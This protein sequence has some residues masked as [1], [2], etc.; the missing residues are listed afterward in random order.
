MGRNGQ[1]RLRQPPLV[2]WLASRPLA[3]SA[4][5][6]IVT[7]AVAVIAAPLIAPY[8]PDAQDLLHTYS[9]PTGQHLLGTDV[10]GRDILSRL[11]YGGRVSLL[12]VVEAVSVMLVLGVAAGATAGYVGGWF[13]RL[14]VWLGDLA[15]ALPGIIILLVVLAVFGRNETAAMVTLGILIAPGLMRVTRGAVLA[16]KQEPYVIAAHVSGLS[17]SQ[18]LVRHVLPL[19]TGPVVVQASIAAASALLV[20]TGIGFLGLGVQPPTPSWGNM[21]AD[22]SNAIYQQSWLLVPSGAIVGITALAFGLVG[23]AVRDYSAARSL[24]PMLPQG[25]ARASMPVAA[26]HQDKAVHPAPSTNGALLSVSNL[27][28]AFPTPSGFQPVALDVSFDLQQGELLG[29]VGESG[30]GKTVT[31]LSILGLLPGGGRIVGGT[32]MFEGQDLVRLSPRDLRRF[33][34]A[35]IGYISQDP[36][37]S[38]DPVFTVRSQLTEVVRT[39]DK[40]SRAAARSRALELLRM[41]NLDDPEALARRHPYELSGGMAQ[42]VGIAMALAGR[43]QLLIADEPTTALDVTVQAEILD[44]LR[45]LQ[46]TTNMSVILVTH[47]WGV[48]ADFCSRVLVMYAGQLVEY[49]GAHAMFRQPL[50]PYTEGLL[51]SDP[52]SA[53]IGQRLTA[54]PGTVPPPHAWPTGCHFHPRCHYATA[55]CAL[56]PIPLVQAA[57]DRETRCIRFEELRSAN[58]PTLELGRNRVG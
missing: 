47:D 56:A 8:G 58:A 25:A 53:A 21:I 34:G 38:L 17:R 1:S 36:E 48:V 43:P 27:S 35:K 55:E 30:C 18:I 6:F 24:G 10:L 40:V 33:R 37:T 42:R 41:V 46:Q 28:V 12:G 20:E 15:L 3:A 44:L 5:L 2:R 13:E 57:P 11:L 9:G 19:I 52:H 39:H 32:V 26:R 49:A 22:A 14:V 54:I 50:H 7:V 31:A 16:V 29:I 4:V 51:R 23:D 45:S